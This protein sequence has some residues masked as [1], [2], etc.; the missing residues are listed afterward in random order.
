MLEVREPAAGRTVPRRLDLVVEN[1][2]AV[3]PSPPE[4]TVRT[5]GR[6]RVVNRAGLRR[7][8]A[9]GLDA[10]FRR[11]DTRLARGIARLS[12][13]RGASYSSSRT[14]RM[15]DLAV[16]VPL[17]L[18]VIPLLAVLL[19]VNKVLHPRYPVLFVQPRVRGAAGV[20]NV[21]KIRSLLPSRFVGGSATAAG[22]STAFGHF[23][24]RH[25]LDELPQ[26]FQVLTGDLSVV[27]VRV[28]P[29]EVYDGL[30]AGW[31]GERF[32]AWQAMYS[33]TPLGLSGVQQVF[34]RTGKEDARRFHRDMFYA[35]HASLGFDLYL[36]WRTLGSRDSEPGRQQARA[37][38][39][40]PAT[41]TSVAA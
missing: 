22:G 29:R 18:L 32:A 13:A 27:G 19:T 10:Y 7:S 11:R 34:R 31:S 35:R 41:A 36:L 8:S 1:G 37:R 38:F 4:R 40:R 5:P 24:R 21:V 25:Y 17:A 2:L 16:A 39:R 9:A 33:S 26:L 12:P 14:R 15:L 3:V 20:I 30:A 23:I 6:R 28:L